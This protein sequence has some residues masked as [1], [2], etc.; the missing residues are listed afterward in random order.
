MNSESKKD[1][2]IEL[3]VIT[4]AVSNVPLDVFLCELPSYVTSIDLYLLRDIDIERLYGTQGTTGIAQF[5]ASMDDGDIDK[6][7]RH[8]KSSLDR[9]RRS[10]S[11][12]PYCRSDVHVKSLATYFP[13]ISNPK[14][15]P[16]VKKALEQSIKI[17]SMLEC[18]CIEIVCGT[19]VDPGDLTKKAS[20]GSEKIEPIYTIKQV[21]EKI[22]ELINVLQCLCNLAEEKEVCFSL[23]MEY[24][25][26][27]L[28]NCSESINTLFSMISGMK[29]SDR[30]EK[31]VGLNLDIGH[32][33]MMER[34]DP[35]LYDT[36]QKNC[37]RIIHSHI[38]DNAFGHFADLVP[39]TI[40]SIE[41][42]GEFSRWINLWLKIARDTSIQ[43][44]FF[45]KTIS[46]ELECAPTMH[47]MTDGLSRVL[48]M[49]NHAQKQNAMC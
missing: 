4:S 16:M 3:S 28:L 14:E 27:H 7:I 43:H 1:N 38:S 34:D 17:A 21:D 31:H 33:L 32:A 36:I 47:W 13:Q 11:N 42:N 5:I 30:L 26:F 12:V 49:I 10:R 23:E 45:T 8:V 48:Y 41:P 44:R 9:C 2:T 35:S 37:G 20:D 24:G 25:P 39:G 18:K 46:L 19:I 40:H 15:A 22:K 6:L 29:E